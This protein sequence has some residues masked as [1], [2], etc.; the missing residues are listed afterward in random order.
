MANKIF[1]ICLHGA[2]GWQV[3]IFVVIVVV[4]DDFEAKKHIVLRMAL[5]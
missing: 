1:F 2:F 3:S 5:E 4:M